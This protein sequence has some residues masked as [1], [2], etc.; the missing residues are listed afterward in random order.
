[1]ISVNNMFQF[2]F[3]VNVEKNDPFSL[4]AAVPFLFIHRKDQTAYVFGYVKLNLIS[5]HILNPKGKIKL[6]CFYNIIDITLTS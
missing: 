1:M 4:T 6:E 5:Y 3:L 2:I